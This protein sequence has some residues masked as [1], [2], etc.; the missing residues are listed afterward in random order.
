MKQQHGHA[1]HPGS[2]PVYRSLLI[3]TVLSFIAMYWLMYAM[4]DRLG[5]VYNNLNQVYMAGL[6]TGAMVLIELAVMRHMYTNRRLNLAVAA[7]GTIALVACWLGI[8]QQVGIGDRQFLRSMI[9][10]HA[11]AILMC[12]QAPI[13]DAEVKRLCQGIIASQQSEINLMAGMLANRNR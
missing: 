7:S 10:H 3:M 4:V 6:M 12:E 2:G 5:N 8:R 1:N 11:G 13:E 9:P